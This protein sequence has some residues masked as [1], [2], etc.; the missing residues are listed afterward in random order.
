ME[1]KQILF[2][3]VA[4]RALAE[5][6]VKAYTLTFIRHSDNVTFKVEGPGWGAYLLRIHV[7]V[8]RAMGAH[9]ADSGAVNSE[10]L[11][12]E[13][14][15]RD[16]DL[17]LQKPVRNRAGALVTQVPAENA[18]LPVN[19]TLLHWVDG[20]PYHRGLE[21]EQTAR[22]I[23]EI[24]AELHIHASRWEIP[25]G[26]KRPKRNAAYFEEALRGIQ[27][28]LE[29]GRI[30]PAD[31]SE[32]ETSMTLLAETLR[33]L[34]EG[35]QTHGIV[36]AD[37]HKGN[38]LYHDGEIRLI[39]FSFCAFGNYMFDLGICFS[40]MKESLHRAFLEGYQSLRALPDGH[41]RLVEGFFVGSMVGTLSH[42]VA[43]PHAQE[44]LAVK[45][46]QIARDYAARF[47]RGEYFW[48]S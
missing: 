41:R 39:D 38:M 34:D 42:W 14:L 16:T 12:L 24:L 44:M 21:S 5:Y 27:P 48:F 28:A 17:V 7:P 3:D 26:F 15:S 18:A 36:H 47:N 40:D 29:D 4:G 43:N 33:S 13:A 37:T 9:G 20:Q 8:T 32:L 31:Y 6:D 2:N 35:R 19:C 10:L 11:W 45:V 23:G 30:S 25:E 46:P 22:Q 1:E